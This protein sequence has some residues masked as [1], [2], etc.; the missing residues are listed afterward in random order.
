MPTAT[1]PSDTKPGT[2][3]SFKN[4]TRVQVSFVTAAEKRALAW[5]A[6]HMPAWV[7]SDDLTILGFAAQIMVG[8][9]VSPLKGLGYLRHARCAHAKACRR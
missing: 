5:F 8:V 6:A 9:S 1:G 7:G 3:P 4:A 2:P